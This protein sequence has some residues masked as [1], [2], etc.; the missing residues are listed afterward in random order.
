MPT[1]LNLDAPCV[2]VSNYFDWLLCSES[3]LTDYQLFTLMQEG[4]VI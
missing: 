3:G 2:P 4:G 1:K